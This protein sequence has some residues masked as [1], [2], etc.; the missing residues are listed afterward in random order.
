MFTNHFKLTVQPFLEWTPVERLQQDDRV[1][2]GLARLDYLA[3]AGC[4]AVVTGHTGVGKSS[5]VKL[6]LNSLSPNRYNPVYLHLTHVNALGLLKLIVR[7]LGEVP[8]RGKE[9]LF[10]QILEKSEATELT[11]I[12]VI[13]EGHLTEP[14]ALIDLRLLVSS[15]LADRPPLKL[16]LTGQ[17]S[18]WDQL[19]R[20]A[21]ADF[22]QRIT[23]RYHL[24]SLTRDQTAEYIDF[25]M[26]TAG[27]SDKVFEPEAKSLIHDYAG[28]VPRQINSIATACLI[29]GASKKV[30]KI[31]EALA[32]E[33]MAEFRLP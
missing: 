32:N 12:L 4:I 7:S 29:N 18:L 10:L 22:V 1:T 21:H 3:H 13:D 15:A 30:Q 11:I 14:H 5:L 26:R 31:S 33:A 19:K 28:G 25:Q 17:D 9:N 16:I 23:V 27:G 20:T 6:F 8:K 2:Q 24:P